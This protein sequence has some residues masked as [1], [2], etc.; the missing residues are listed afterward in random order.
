MHAVAPLSFF[1][2]YP[3]PRRDLRSSEKS[4][5]DGAVYVVSEPDSGCFFRL[6]AVEYFITQQLDG[7]LPLKKSAVA[8]RHGLAAPFLPKYLNAFLLM[9]VL[10]GC[11]RVSGRA[12]RNR[13]QAGAFAA[14]GF[15]SGSMPLIRV[16]V[17]RAASCSPVWR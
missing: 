5:R 11:W 13:H 1:G 3:R 8:P 14:I 7:P 9:P 6:G 2:S 10:L 15:T 12:F 16:S 17:S 4:T